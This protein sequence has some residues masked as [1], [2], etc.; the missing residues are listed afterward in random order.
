MSQEELGRGV[1]PEEQLVAARAQLLRLSQELAGR[2]ERLRNLERHVVELQLSRYGERAQCAALLQ[3]HPQP[4][5]PWVARPPG[6]LPDGKPGQLPWWMW[7]PPGM[8]P[9]FGAES[10]A[11]AAA[12]AASVWRTPSCQQVWGSGSA[13]LPPPGPAEW[14]TPTCVA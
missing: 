10:Q 2:D 14:P 1:S 9:D 3:E 7:L 5:C 8:P 11:A 12:A 4:P 6:M 13:G